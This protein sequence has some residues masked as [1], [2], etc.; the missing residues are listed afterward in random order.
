[1]LGNSPLKDDVQQSLCRR[2]KK[3][4]IHPREDLAG[5]MHIRASENFDAPI[6]IYSPI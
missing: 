1:M 3:P 6:V 4:I 5:S 2:L